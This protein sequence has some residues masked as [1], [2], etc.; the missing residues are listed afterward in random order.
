M[1]SINKPDYDPKDVYLTCI[2]RVKNPV[3]KARLESVAD[4]VKTAA[5]VYDQ[6]AI[7]GRLYTTLE[8]TNVAGI[9]TKS[10]MEKVY[11]G[12]MAKVKVP[13]RP[14]YDR[15]KASAH[16][17]IC[18]FCGQRVV[19]QLD[20]YLPKAHFPVLSVVPFNLV[21]SCSDCN[22]SKLSDVPSSE[23]EQTFHPYYDDVTTE[24]WLY[25]EVIEDAVATMRFF[26]SVPDDWGEV[27]QERAKTHFTT[28]GLGDLYVSQ[29]GVEFSNIRSQLE[30][31]FDKAGAEAVREH[32]NESAQ[33]RYANHIN[34]WQTAMYQAMSDSGWFCNGGF[35]NI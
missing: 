20:H 12:R 13:G 5:E 19:S 35:L 24:Q 25:A 14:I 6:N 15:I 11:T 8:H 17:G 33:S 16:H 32:L 1:R 9:I 30:K 7:D 26:V 10:E 2:S 4:N 3:L 18:P 28:F 34:S 22:K 23:E 31:L 27:L 21:P 29:A